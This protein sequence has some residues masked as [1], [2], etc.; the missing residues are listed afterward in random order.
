MSLPQPHSCL[1]CTLSQ[2]ETGVR[3]RDSGSFDLALTLSQSPCSFHSAERGREWCKKVLGCGLEI[4]E[5]STSQL[6]IFH[7][8]EFSHMFYWT[9][10]KTK[11]CI[12]LLA[13]E[14]E[15]NP[16]ANREEISVCIC[17]LVT[18]STQCEVD[19]NYWFLLGG[20]TDAL[21]ASAYLWIIL[22][23]S[24]IFQR[25]NILIEKFL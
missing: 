11:T 6:P 8:P 16:D 24:F 3:G 21:L 15:Q 23:N 19:N 1:C 7:C 10:G 20:K 14:P 12:Q 25:N 22:N 9:T 2:G 5:V 18:S 17:F 13:Q 4:W